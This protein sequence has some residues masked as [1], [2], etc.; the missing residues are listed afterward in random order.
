MKTEF[1]KFYALSDSYFSIRQLFCQEN[2]VTC[3]LSTHLEPRPKVRTQDGVRTQ[4]IF[5]MKLSFRP[6]VVD[7]LVKLVVREYLKPL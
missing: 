2:T 5:H 1:C 7:Y 4:Q 6:R 3:H